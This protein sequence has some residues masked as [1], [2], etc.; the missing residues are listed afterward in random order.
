LRGTARMVEGGACEVEV[1]TVRLRAAREAAGPVFVA[2]APAHVTLHRHQPEGSARNVIEGVVTQA[3]P[4]AGRVRVTL[5]TT[6]GLILVAEV[7]RQS[8]IELDLSPGTSVYA[9]FK[10]TESE[11]YRSA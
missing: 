4:M 11:A 1:G 8:S 5:S 7:T 6:G 2:I 9:S 3:V 10:A